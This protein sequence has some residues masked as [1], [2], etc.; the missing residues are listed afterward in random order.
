V[1]TTGLLLGLLAACTES[2]L[3]LFVP[4][5]EKGQATSAYVPKTLPYL[6][7]EAP[8]LPAAFTMGAATMDLWGSVCEPPQ[9]LPEDPRFECDDTRPYVAP[10]MTRLRQIG[11][12]LVLVTDFAHLY[13]DRSLRFKFDERFGDHSMSQAE[14]NAITKAAH[15]QG[16]QAMLITNVDDGEPGAMAA[17]DVAHADLATA[18]ALHHQWRQLMTVQA[19]RAREAG[20]DVLVANWRNLGQDFGPR[21]AEVATQW[22]STFRT[23]KTAFG[24]KLAF[25][26]Q[27]WYFKDRP[28]DWQDVDVAIV[29]NMIHHVMKDVP[30]DLAA[31]TGA[32]KRDFVDYRAAKARLGP[33]KSILSLIL[34]PSFDGALQKGW[35]EPVARYPEG[36]YAVDWREQALVYEGYFRAVAEDQPPIDGVIAYNYWWNDRMPP[37]TWMRIDLGHSIRGKDAETVFANWAQ[38]VGGPTR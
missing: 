27:T 29:D 7:A 12:K 35:I 24:G 26:H 18:H 14:L 13:K 36:A 6:P 10:V 15:D 37:K 31:I 22:P 9:R 32:W 1:V 5:A 17:L 33:G 3:P 21:D 16:L 30:E 34:M 25:W 4:V 19:K 11:A 28:V 8:N 20:F 38:R 23:L 2:F